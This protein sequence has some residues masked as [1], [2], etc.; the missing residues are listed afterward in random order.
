MSNFT[1]IGQSI[2]KLRVQIFTKIAIT[3]QTFAKN[4]YTEF[5]ED[6]QPIVKLL[7]KVAD[8][9]VGVVTTPGVP[10]GKRILKVA[11]YHKW[12]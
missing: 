4:S 5:H 12:A 10:Y 2:R 11:R 9:L 6:S 8:A 7:Y 3:R 1:K